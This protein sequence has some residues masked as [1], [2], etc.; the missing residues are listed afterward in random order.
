MN[1]IINKWAIVRR[2]ELTV[3]PDE[4]E[5]HPDF[6]RVLTREDF[7]AA[8]RQVGN[9]FFQ[10]MTDISQTPEWIELKSEAKYSRS[11]ISVN[12]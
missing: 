3:A 10:I 7:E 9:M 8:F 4:I 1:Y 11:S 5:I 6:L 12:S 2:G